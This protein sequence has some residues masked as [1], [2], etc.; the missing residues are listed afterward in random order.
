MNT[1]FTRLFP[2]ADAGFITL[3]AAVREARVAY[4]RICTEGYPAPET[5]YDTIDRLVTDTVK[6]VQDGTPLP[7]C[8]A[9][10]D[11]RRAE[12]VAADQAEV[13]R[14]AVETLAAQVRASVDAGEVMTRHLQ[15]AHTE[16]VKQLCAALGVVAAH[17]ASGTSVLLAS[18]KVRA[19]E[20]SIDE[21]VERYTA[22]RQ[23]RADL[24]ITCSYAPAL[25]VDNEFG[26]V[27]NPEDVWTR[28][29]HRNFSAGTPRC[30][31]RSWS[32]PPS[33]GSA[34]GCSPPTPRAPE[35]STGRAMPPPHGTVLPAPPRQAQGG[36]R[37]AAVPPSPPPCCHPHLHPGQAGPG[38]QGATRHRAHVLPGTAH[39]HR[40]A[41]P[42][43]TAGTATPPTCAPTHRA[44]QARPGTSGSR[45]Q[46]RHQRQPA[47][48]S[49]T[50][51]APAPRC[52][53]QDAETTDTNPGGIATGSAVTCPATQCPCQLHRQPSD[54]R[55]SVA[56][57]RPTVSGQPPTR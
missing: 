23:A 44:Q 49:A 3:P 50:P 8:G 43:G 57:G 48:A 56:H 29:Q 19:A 14:M 37:G 46:P 41:H 17:H 40:P 27:R 30:T 21:L 15:P 20:A 1:V 45:R 36:A 11:A 24:D 33:S 9:V 34:K 2:A 38:G 7:D 13:L 18:Q 53:R 54:D 31:P 10:D 6:A 25:D 16:V 28:T 47:T 55:R 22:I 52:R 51:I 42:P 12:Q 4:D 26:E 35:V 5:H 32:K 39:R